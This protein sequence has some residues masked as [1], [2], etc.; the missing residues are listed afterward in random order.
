ML[1]RGIGAAMLVAGCTPSP[2]DA[3]QRPTPVPLHLPARRQPLEPAL[4]PAGLGPPWE[5]V[6]EWN[7]VGIPPKQFSL[8]DIP[9]Q[10]P[11]LAYA[12]L[13][14]DACEAE[15]RRREIAFERGQ[16]TPGVRAPIRL[17]GPLHGVAAHSTSEPSGERPRPES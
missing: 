7:S 3:W 17:R 15:L 6:S 13:D 10:S 12:A 8:F 5:A 16:A 11:V 4:E 14:R 9:P 2:S 1:Y